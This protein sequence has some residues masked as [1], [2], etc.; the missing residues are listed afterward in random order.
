[1]EKNKLEGVKPFGGQF[2]F[3]SCF[4]H[5]LM[6]AAGA[7][8]ID[9]REL[10]LEDFIYYEKNFRINQNILPMSEMYKS[11]GISLRHINVPNFET[12]AEHIDKGFPLFIGVDTFYYKARTDFYRK[13][14]MPHFVLIYG[15]DRIKKNFYIIDHEYNNSYLFKEKEWEAADILYASDMYA[16]GICLYKATCIVMRHRKIEEK[17]IWDKIVGKPSLIDESIKNFE[18]DL[19]IIKSVLS[20]KRE[21]LSEHC[22]RISGFFYSMHR[23]RACLAES[24]IGSKSERLKKMLVD[25]SNKDAFFRAVFLRLEWWNDYRFIDKNKGMLFE[26]LDELGQAEKTF[27]QEVKNLK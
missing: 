13:K 27:F 8:G 19:Q 5:E 12:V 14:H 17:R 9:G 26:K 4:Y 23:K 1:M 15:Y 25:I 18:A 2:W 7:F 16:K 20:D 10:L 24:T 22:K 6:Y 3:R 11:M 21:S